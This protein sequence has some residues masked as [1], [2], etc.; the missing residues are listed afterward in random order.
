MPF[1]LERLAARPTALDGR[2]EA[3]DEAVA[4]CAQIQRIF[5][6]RTV[7]GSGAAALVD[8]GLPN[9]VE[10]GHAEKPALARFAE[11]ARRAIQK[12]E[13]RLKDVNVTVEPQE[14]S[15]APFRLQIVGALADR[16]DPY[17]FYIPLTR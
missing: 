16:D 5:A 17:V 4:V 12:Y 7:P 15:L 13:P 3:F 14:D 11:L 6:G 10:M 8:W 1:L 2:Q 9:A